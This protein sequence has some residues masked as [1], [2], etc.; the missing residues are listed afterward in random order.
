MGKRV[1]RPTHLI[2][3]TLTPLTTLFMREIGDGLI[4]SSH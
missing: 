4:L 1:P 3:P 2:I